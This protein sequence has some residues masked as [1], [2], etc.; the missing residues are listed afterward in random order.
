MTSLANNVTTLGKGLF[1]LNL[2]SIVRGLRF[3][4]KAAQKSL[5]DTYQVVDPFS[6][7]AQGE[8]GRLLRRI[9]EVE[10]VEAAPWPEQILL[11]MRYAEVSGS[12]P[13]RDIIAILCLAIERAPKA[14]LEFG[15]FWGS[16]TVN[17]AKN[18]PGA[19]VKRIADTVVATLKVDAADMRVKR[20]LSAA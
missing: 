14:A 4:P 3:G 12:T 15:T 6:M 16:G 8:A 9:P 5:V 19:T 11:D 7:L 17:L 2:A 18:L 20:L 1:A 13:L 10:M